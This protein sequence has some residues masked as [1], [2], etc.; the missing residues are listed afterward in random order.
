M[1]LK[2]LIMPT[3]LATAFLGTAVAL[4]TSV[5]NVYASDTTTTTTADTNKIY[6]VED[7]K[8][9]LK[10]TKSKVDLN[11]YIF[12]IKYLVSEDGQKELKAIVDRKDDDA[13]IFKHISGSVE[14]DAN[15]FRIAICDVEHFYEVRFG[16]DENNEYSCLIYYSKLEDG[17]I[18]PESYVNN[19]LIYSSVDDSINLDDYS[20]Y[21][22]EL[23][24]Y[25]GMFLSSV[26][27]ITFSTDEKLF[28]ALV[29]EDDYQVVER[30][31]D[32]TLL[33]MFNYSTSDVIYDTANEVYFIQLVNDINDVLLKD[34]PWYE[35]FMDDVNEWVDTNYD[36]LMLSAVSLTAVIGLLGLGVYFFRKKRC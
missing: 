34:I 11:N 10:E 21:E 19:E 14:F 22:N 16:Y 33:S 3:M 1:K 29:N 17:L 18:T 4:G 26:G 24:G 25:N 28:N 31:V 8:K 35:T 27:A 30:E 23:T 2:K 32:N 7:Y 36:K 12:D 9:I 5:S 15:N 13:E 6:T 20:K